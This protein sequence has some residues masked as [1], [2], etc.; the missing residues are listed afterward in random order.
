[1]DLDAYGN[2]IREITVYGS[3]EKVVKE[4]TY[5][6]FIIPLQ[7]LSENDKIMIELSKDQQVLK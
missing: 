4:T 1:M 7:Y 6:P 2:A 5:Q 3:K